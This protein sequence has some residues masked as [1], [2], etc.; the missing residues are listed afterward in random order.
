M[1]SVLRDT[2]HCFSPGEIDMH[3]VL[4]TPS[5]L[6]LLCETSA[7]T[8]GSR[9][10]IEYRCFWQNIVVVN[11]VSSCKE[12]RTRGFYNSS[13]SFYRQVTFFIKLQ[14]LPLRTR[15]AHRRFYKYL[16]ISSY[17]AEKSKRFFCSVLL[18]FAFG[19]SDSS[20][21][22][23]GVEASDNFKLFFV[24]RTALSH[25][26]IFKKI[27][28]SLLNKLLKLCFRI[29]ALGFFRIFSKETLDYW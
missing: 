26:Y 20:A 6:V 24:I 5:G 12:K 15:S 22:D 10:V 2:A 17:L 14:K 16:M 11:Y 1:R 7:Q 19:S 23:V 27:S 18:C 9:K 13:S 8:K 29:N 21:Y 4:N 3:Y 28:L 25:D